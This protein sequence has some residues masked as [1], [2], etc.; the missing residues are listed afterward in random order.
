MRKRLS[1]VGAFFFL[2]LTFLSEVM[3]SLH[4]MISFPIFPLCFSEEIEGTCTKVSLHSPIIL[5]REHVFR[6]KLKKVK[7]F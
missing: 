7:C 2:D 4:L 3:L 5:F 6:I 1:V